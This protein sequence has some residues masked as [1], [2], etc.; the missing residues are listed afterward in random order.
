[1]AAAALLVPAFILLA[2]AVASECLGKVQMVLAAAL[3]SAV[4]VDQADRQEL[5]RGF[6]PTHLYAKVV[7]AD[8]LVEADQD[9]SL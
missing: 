7:T 8:F 3:R 6:L 2:A 4:V 5:V 9:I 1:M